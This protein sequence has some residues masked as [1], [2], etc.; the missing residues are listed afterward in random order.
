MKSDKELAKIFHDKGL[1]TQISTI[2]SC[3]SGLSA[4]IVE[5]A[6]EVL[7]NDH[8]AIYDGSWSEYVELKLIY[9]YR[10]RCLNLTSKMEAGI[11][12]VSDHH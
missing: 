4:C 5:L 12:L 7:D 2:C 1:D 3:G 6:L 10:A 9:I 11:H 8:T